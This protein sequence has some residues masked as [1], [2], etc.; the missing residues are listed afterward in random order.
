MTDSNKPKPDADA[1]RRRMVRVRRKL[2]RHVDELVESSK[3]LGDW[4]EYVKAQPVA[5]AGLAALAGYLLVPSRP[6]YS[7][8]DPASLKRMARK[9]NLVVASDAK[10]KP[11]AGGPGPIAV[12]VT[13]ALVRMAATWLGG[14]FGKVMGDATAATNPTENYSPSETETPV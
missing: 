14:Q 11:H 7:E 9:G 6:M 1:I 3:T 2:D 10:V 4:R 12:L 8:V 13:G 5:F